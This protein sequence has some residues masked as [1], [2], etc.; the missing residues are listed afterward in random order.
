LLVNFSEKPLE[1]NLEWEI[2]RHGIDMDLKYKRKHYSATF[3]PEVAAEEGWDQRT[4]LL[5]LLLKDGFPIEDL[6]GP[7]DFDKLIKKMKITTY[8]SI[9]QEISYS[10][11]KT[12]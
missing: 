10:E 3:L 9:K 4:T 8:E 12:L 7:A 2:G 5:E 6:K 11:F 1:N